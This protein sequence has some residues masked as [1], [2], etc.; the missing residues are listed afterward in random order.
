M[1]KRDLAQKLTSLATQFPAVALLGPRQSGKTTLAKTLFSHYQ[2]FSFE[3]LDIR[4]LA[5]SDPRNFLER[6]KDAPGVLFDEVQRVAL[7]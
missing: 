6:Y 5:T 7:D 3:D 1:I 2:Y 4:A